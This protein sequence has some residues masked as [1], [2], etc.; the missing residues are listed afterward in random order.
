VQDAGQLRALAAATLAEG[1]VKAAIRHASD[2]LQAMG[3]PAP[4][5]AYPLLPPA[6]AAQAKSVRE[7]RVLEDVE[8]ASRARLTDGLQ[9]Y[10]HWAAPYRPPALRV[11]AMHRAVALAPNLILTADGQLL[12]DNIGFNN[13]ELCDHMPADFNG[14]VA[15]GGRL[16]VAVRHRDVA[17]VTGPALY[18]P[19]ASNYAAWLFGSLPRL[20]A[21]ADIAGIAEDNDLPIV[22]HGEVAAYHLDS[23]HAMGIARERLVIHGAH[24]RI[25]CKELYY[26]T[27]SYFHHAPSTVGVRHVRERV[28]AHLGSPGETA[29]KRLYLARRHAKDRPLLNEAEV[30]TLF[31]RHGFIAIDP[32]CHSFAEQVKFAANAEILAG[33]YGANLANMVFAGRARKLLILG[34]KHQPEFA[35]LASALGIAFWHTV[36]QGVALREGR[37]M[38]ESF[39]FNADLPELDR[40]LHDCL[41]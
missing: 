32:E 36:P 40:V 30:V 8:I 29:G 7:I 3:A 24:V 15:A 13:T 19:A 21:Y 37:T 31:E 41:V 11:F 39:G 1:R 33:P 27:T 9:Q 34:T 4:V 17:R 20:A 35:R 14:I 23:L 10:V 6:Q 22:L 26:C 5:V 28:L 38:S 16:L 18:L 2:C 12:D 25:E